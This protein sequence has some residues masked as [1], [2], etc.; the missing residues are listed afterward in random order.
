MLVWIPP[1]RGPGQAYQVR[2]DRTKQALGIAFYQPFT[3]LWLVGWLA[4]QYLENINDG[5]IP[6]FVALIIMPLKPPRP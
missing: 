3:S 6:F 1:K 5:E 2:D 4:D